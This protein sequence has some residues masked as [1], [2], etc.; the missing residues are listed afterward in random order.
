M[1]P[2]HE[3]TVRILMLMVLARD[4]WDTSMDLIISPP[5]QCLSK[6]TYLMMTAHALQRPIARCTYETSC[7]IDRMPGANRNQGFAR[8]RTGAME[9]PSPSKLV[10]DLA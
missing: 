8:R 7:R 6:H 5:P 10:L 2:G 1:L 9:H 4:H 3:T